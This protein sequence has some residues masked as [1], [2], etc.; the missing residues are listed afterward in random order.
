MTPAGEHASKLLS[1]SRDNLYV[2]TRLA[3]DADAPHGRS[4]FMR[5][6]RSRG[7]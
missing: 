6:R 7:P 5:S 4:A 1:K 3:N 2:V